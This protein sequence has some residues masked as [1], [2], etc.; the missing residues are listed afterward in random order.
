MYVH[1]LFSVKCS[2]HNI[3]SHVDTN[4]VAY[5]NVDFE[6]VCTYICHYIKRSEMLK[7]LCGTAAFYE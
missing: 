5:I 1:I 7:Q 6:Y 2:G 3:Y 4:A